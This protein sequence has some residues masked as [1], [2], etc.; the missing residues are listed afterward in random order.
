MARRPNS[1]LGLLWYLTKLYADK[2]PR[3][4]SA[5]RGLTGVVALVGAVGV[6]ALLLSESPAEVVVEPAPAAAL[7]PDGCPDAVEGTWVGSQHLR[8]EEYRFEVTI[9]RVQPGSEELEGKIVSTWWYGEEGS[10]APATCDAG[11]Q[12]VVEMGATG[13][14][15]GGQLEFFGNDWKALEGPCGV[16]E[17]VYNLDRLSG[18]WRESDHTFVMINDDGGNPLTDVVLVRTACGR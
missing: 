12:S 4:A 14:Y 2:H 5:A 16:Y 15:R 9:R 7:A 11:F 6:G 10:M 1:V 3:A 18:A 17:G 13:R 8:S